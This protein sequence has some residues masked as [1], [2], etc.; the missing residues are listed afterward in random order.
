MVE[1]GNRIVI[2][3]HRPCPLQ[4]KNQMPPPSH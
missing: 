1:Y 2:Q 4:E 3:D